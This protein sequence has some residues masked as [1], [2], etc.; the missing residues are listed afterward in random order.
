[1]KT[2]HRILV[3]VSHDTASEESLRLAC[4]LARQSKAKVYVVYVI[5]VNRSLPLDA[6]IPSDNA[7]S[8][9]VLTRAEGIAA[10]ED[11]EIETDLLQA[12]DVATAVI[13]EAL[14]REVDLVIMG[15]DYKRRFGFFHISDTVFHIFRDSP[16][17]VI[18]LQEPPPKAKP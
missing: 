13:E 7:E 3:P 8:E 17:R 2:L 10:D 9:V 12:R 16:C 11:V 1:M 5:E 6:E 14:E 4:L 18:L 15:T